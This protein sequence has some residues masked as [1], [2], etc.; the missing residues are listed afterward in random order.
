MLT[1]DAPEQIWVQ[2]KLLE[3]IHH[4]EIVTLLNFSGVLY[5]FLNLFLHNIIINF[6]TTPAKLPLHS[7]PALLFS[8]SHII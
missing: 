2:I 3:A 5:F 8:S 4:L 7:P 6:T 1:V